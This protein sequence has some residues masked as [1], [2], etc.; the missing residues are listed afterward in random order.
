VALNGSAAGTTIPAIVAANVAAHGA[1]VV[2]RKK[3]RGIWKAVTWTELATHVRD[4]AAGLTGAGFGAGQVGGVLS[5][6]RPEAAYADL[7]ILSMGGAA[8]AIHPDEEPEQLGHILRES[9]CSL[10]FVE[11]EE[12]LDKTLMIRDACPEL[13][14]IVIFDMKGLREFSD[15]HCVSL[16]ACCS[17]A[18]AAPPAVT[19]S[20]QQT[21]ILLYNHGEKL[22]KPR[23]L[24]HGDVI[25]LINNANAMLHLRAGDER[26]AVMPM[27]ALLEHVLGL[28]LSLQTRTVSNYL[29]NPDTVIGNLQEVQP[30]VLGADAITWEALHQ[31]ATRA[32][33]DATY[34]QRALYRWALS[35]GER[36]GAMSGL[37]GM[38][39][40]HAARREL[41]LN[42]L[43]LAY[44]CGKPLPAEI[45]TW[46]ESL[47]IAL[48]RVDGPEPRGT[49]VDARSRALM[50][51][52][53][54][55]A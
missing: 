32:A 17:A 53:Y 35:A 47:G 51:E 8:V 45:S 1:E 39:V 13:R 11:N 46:A 24:T 42:R 30:T 54:G 12:Q 2:F 48:R 19:I 22:G 15:P 26:L 41:G 43:R 18:A 29:E 7:A 28:Y 34:T 37:A 3:D 25:H 40:L 44:V 31:R 33:K 16:A 21:A 55:R 20:E 52:A 27:S 14:Q 23:S 10:L 49:T 38:L 4:I 5:H 50:Q 6:T 36:G 9:N